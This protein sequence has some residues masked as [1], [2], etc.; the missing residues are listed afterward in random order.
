L[1]ALTGI[2]VLLV[3][4]FVGLLITRIA[5]VALVFTGLSR[6]LARFQARSAFTGCGFTTRE[7]EQIVQHPLRR[8]IVMFLML[9]GNGT[10]VVAI[11]SL[12]P[13]FVSVPDEEGN[14]ALSL[15]YRLLWLA[16]GLLLMW[17]LAASK[18]VDRQLSKLIGWALTRFTSLEVQDYHGL[19]RMSEGYT[20]REMEVH[21]GYWVVGKNLAELRLSDEGVQVLGIRRANGDYVGTPTGNTYIRRDDTLVVYGRT[22]HLEELQRRREGDEGD[23]AHEKRITE[24]RAVLEV[25]EEQERQRARNG[26]GADIAA[27]S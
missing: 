8:R 11:S 20:A 10:V 12:I 22:A 19:L 24:Q 25:L 3:A 14:P 26:N 2:I 16:L 21:P 13:V 6:D 4:L 7:A 15:Q 27:D 17:M 9:L 18:W 5:T 23:V 1:E